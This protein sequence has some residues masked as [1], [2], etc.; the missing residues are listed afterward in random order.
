MSSS[1][2]P[3]LQ[4]LRCTPVNS[5]SWDDFVRLLF[6]KWVCGAAGWAGGGG[7]TSIQNGSII[8]DM[9]AVSACNR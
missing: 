2:G 4:L 5:D 1:C 6:K 3:S 7:G 9:S 8:S